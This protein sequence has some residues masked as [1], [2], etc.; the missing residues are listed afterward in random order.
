MTQLYP[1]AQAV[2]D[3]ALYE[4]NAE[5]YA[6]WIAAAVIRA[7]AYGVLPLEDELIDNCMYEKRNPIREKFLAIADELEAL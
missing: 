3:A 1:D 4:V 2:L 5:C 7:A 6:P